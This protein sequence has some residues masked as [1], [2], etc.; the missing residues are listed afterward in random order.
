M[1]MLT[2][3]FVDNNKKT[4]GIHYAYFDFHARCPSKNYKQLNKFINEEL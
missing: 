4:V 1:N 3:T 2:C